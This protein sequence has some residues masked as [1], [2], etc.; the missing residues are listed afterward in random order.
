MRGKAPS[1]LRIT[2]AEMWPQHSPQKLQPR[3]K[4]TISPTIFTL[5]SQDLGQQHK[6]REDHAHVSSSTAH[7]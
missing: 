1:S 6:T 2:T 7:A 4:T 5:K 3:F